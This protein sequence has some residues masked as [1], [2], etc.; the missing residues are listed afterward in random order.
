[1][2]YETNFDMVDLL[3]IVFLIFEDFSRRF[4]AKNGGQLAWKDARMTRRSNEYKRTAGTLSVPSS[5]LFT[6]FRESICE[7]KVE[8]LKIQNG[9]IANFILAVN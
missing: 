3:G 8:F 6:V 7:L 4:C 2:A 9:N 1:M 5:S